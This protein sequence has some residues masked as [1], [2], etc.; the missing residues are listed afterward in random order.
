M[1]AKAGYCRPWRVWRDKNADLAAAVEAARPIEDTIH[2]R[3][4]DERRRRIDAIQRAAALAHHDI[5]D[6]TA[7]TIGAWKMPDFN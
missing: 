1:T 3:D 2:L 5:E 6:L 4:Q 7:A